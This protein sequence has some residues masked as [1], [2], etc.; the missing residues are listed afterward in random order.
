MN[1]E[2]DEKELRQCLSQLKKVKK[3]FEGLAELADYV[4]VAFGEPKKFLITL[5][6]VRTAETDEDMWSCIESMVR[7]AIVD[8]QTLTRKHR[9][10]T[11]DSVML[12][13]TKLKGLVLDVNLWWD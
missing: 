4:T 1:I 11:V 5:E 13:Q 3:H 10:I 8:V 7:G 12:Q 2:M 6:Y 9:Y